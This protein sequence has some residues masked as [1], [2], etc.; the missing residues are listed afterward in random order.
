MCGVLLHGSNDTGAIGHSG[1]LTHVSL[2][3]G[4][5]DDWHV[6]VLAPHQSCLYA[7]GDKDTGMWDLRACKDSSNSRLQK[8]I[9]DTV[10]NGYGV[11]SSCAW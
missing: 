6:L 5:S 2:G 7:A 11:S 1:R 8:L 10:R 3:S 4:W 9:I